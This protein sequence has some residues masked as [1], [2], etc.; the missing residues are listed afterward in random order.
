MRD[1]VATTSLLKRHRASARFKWYGRLSMLLACSFLFF[2]MF[3]IVHNGYYAF[4]QTEIRLTMDIPKGD[5]GISD[6]RVMI[7]DGLAQRFPEVKDSP[8][9]RALHRMISKGARA[10]LVKEIDA[11]P[12]WKGTRQALWIRA[13]SDIDMAEKHDVFID[14]RF[15]SWFSML[16]SAGDIRQS[17]NLRFF[18]GGDSREAELAGVLGSMLGSILIIIVCMGVALPLAVA[19]AVYLEECSKRSLIIDLIEININNLAAVPSIIY[20]LIG[21]SIFINTLDMPRS[22]ALVGGLTLSLMV[23]PTMIVTTRQALRTIPST[24]R[25]GVVALGAS[26]MQVILHH[27]LPLALPG[28]MTG[29][30]LSISRAI[31]ETSP[32]LMVGMVAF[33]ADLPHKFLDPVGAL[34]VQIFLWS[35]SLER[36]FVEKTSAAILVLLAILLVL[37]SVAIYVRRRYEHQW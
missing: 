2:L 33:I 16:K 4:I 11:H 8:D 3:S 10:S 21:L 9:V 35:D 18:T 5:I 24:I 27:V 29:M 13:S 25:Q 12:E 15:R 1:K 36:G 30:I 7:R 19:A 20:G 28:I 34:P 6:A 31:G 37:N 14:Q 23:L 17:F 32:L 26:P 22:S